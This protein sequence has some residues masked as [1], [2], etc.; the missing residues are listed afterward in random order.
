VLFETQDHRGKDV[1]I[2]TSQIRYIARHAQNAQLSVVHFEGDSKV[3]LK[4]EATAL[5]L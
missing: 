3:I 5:T 1:W 2:N 4:H